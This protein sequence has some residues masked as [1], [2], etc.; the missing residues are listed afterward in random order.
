MRLA[1]ILV[2]ILIWPALAVAQNPVCSL[3]TF[4]VRQSE[5]LPQ[6]KH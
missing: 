5:R 4:W 1:V 3:T 2:G 6:R